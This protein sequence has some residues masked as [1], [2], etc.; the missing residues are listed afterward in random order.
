VLLYSIFNTTKKDN[1]N[2][3]LSMIASAPVTI[4]VSDKYHSF[5]KNLCIY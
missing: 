3:L 2:Y 4:L 1:F 5:S